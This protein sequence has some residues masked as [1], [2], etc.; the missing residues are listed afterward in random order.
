MGSRQSETAKGSLQSVDRYIRSIGRHSINAVIVMML[1]IAATY[2]MMVVALDRHSLQQ[3]I[4]FLTS[5]QFIR[6][7]Q[8][9]NQTRALMRASADPNLPEYFI[10][11]MRDDVHLA[12]ADIRAAGRQ[13]TALHEEIGTNFLEKLNSR[14]TTA[15]QVR[16]D[17]D[18]RL[19]DFLDR[20]ARIADTSTKERRERYSFWGPIDFAAAADSIPMR[21]FADLIGRAHDRS[22]R[23]IRNA[24]WIGSC[25]LV[26]IATIVIL[27][28]TLLFRPLL[29]KLRNEHRRT[30][31][32][33]S[34]LSTLAHTDA[35]TGLSNRSSFNLA[36]GDLFIGL[37]RTGA[38]F[39]LLL[40]DLD[41]FK[42]IND[43]LGHPAGD[44][45]L[46]HVA[47]ALQNAVR[48]GDVIARL[49]GDEF[50]V[51]LPGVC[52]APVLEAIAMRANE[53]IAAGTAFEGRSLQASASI[54]GAVVPN[55]ATDE[56][57]L[58]RV[59][60]LAL[61]TA[62]GNR[63]TAVIFDEAALARRLEQ[64][65][66]ALALVLAADRNEYV[67]HYQ[68]KVDLS[69]GDYVGFEA[70][71]RW[72][73]PQLG[74]L[75]PGRFL[76]LME[77]TQLIR[78]MTRA[79]VTIVGRDLAEWKAAGLFPGSISVNLPEALLVGAEG[80]ELIA[81]AIQTNGLD[82]KDFAIEITEDVF[83]NR[84]A[85]QILATVTRFRQHGL[86]ISLDDFG[87][88]FASLLHLRDFPF[89]EIKID[90][91]FVAGIG[92]DTRS[93]QIIRAMIDLSRNLGK[94]SVAEGIETE[95]QRRFLATAGCEVGQGYLFAKPQPAYQARERLSALLDTYHR[96]QLVGGRQI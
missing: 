59:V 15:E 13:L 85:D 7:Q 2:Q 57:T 6:F 34:R 46:R 28:S 64:N 84:C 40:V 53:A 41:H 70:L 68:P 50:A 35:L 20:A 83:L 24:K 81:E 92:T 93:E 79:V 61:Y 27:A 26:L 91:S 75:P 32:F 90:R 55:H 37:E 5:N 38:G 11:P 49:G 69:T 52:D 10:S 77:G 31:D 60:D 47:R 86:S 67:V 51:L 19:E 95:E 33:E 42:S 62:K 87:T 30:S 3:N 18:E 66:L 65:Q 88:G 29:K 36:L 76:P 21:Q 23:S 9:A 82:W 73:H 4:S 25:L 96:P 39:S 12:I 44:A 22:D 80:Y 89:D 48:S 8:L 45:V 94:R 1:L 72:Q 63:N 71:V 58:M 54:G 16:L 74:L 14:D 17:L 78:G 56:A 43:S